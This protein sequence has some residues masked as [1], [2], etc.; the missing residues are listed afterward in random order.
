M[1]IP[2]KTVVVTKHAADRMRER[3]VC[4]PDKIQRTAEKAWK[5]EQ[6]SWLLNVKKESW[7]G[8]LATVDQ[9]ELRAMRRGGNKIFRWFSG[10]LY[11]YRYSGADAVKL[12]TVILPK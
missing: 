10:N 3:K 1:P 2:S 5:S 11:V 8:K 7:R 6:K 4:R 12:I 9:D